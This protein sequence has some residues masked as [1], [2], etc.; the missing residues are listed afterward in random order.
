MEIKH[1]TDEEIIA[2]NAKR[3]DA[4]GKGCVKESGECWIVK[5]VSMY[6]E[7]DVCEVRKVTDVNVLA[8][9]GEARDFAAKM[10]RNQE[11]PD[12]CIKVAYTFESR[13]VF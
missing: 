5:A 2:M 4:T 10:T 6:M 13:W 12:S 11:H 7:G 1:I 3:I 8:T 9:E